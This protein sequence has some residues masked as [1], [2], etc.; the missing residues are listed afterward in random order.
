MIT[1]YHTKELPQCPS[2]KKRLGL[3]SISSYEL[4]GKLSPSGKLSVGRVPIKK[5][6]RSD[7]EYERTR[8]KYHFYQRRH[9]H[10]QQGLVVEN[11]IRTIEPPGLGL[12][13]VSNCHK[14]NRVSRHGLKGISGN[15]RKIVRESCYV[16]EQKYRK[17]LGFYTLTCPYTD[18]ESIYSYNKNIAYIQRSFFQELKRAYERKGCTWSYVS[19][20]EI[21]AKRYA[22]TGVPVLHIH[23]ISPCY[24]PGTYSWILKADEIRNIWG[25]VLSNIIFPVSSTQASID[26]VVIAK[27][28]TGYISKYMSKGSSEVAFLAEICPGQLPSQWWSTSRNVRACVRAN[29]CVLPLAVCQSFIGGRYGDCVHPDDVLY[30]RNIYVQWNAEMICVGLTA[31]IADRSAVSLRPFLEWQ[32]MYGYL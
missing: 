29:T 5:I 2:T 12:S 30:L 13:S 17:R 20:L 28:A 26:A 7:E 10:Y 6:L 8:G 1:R 16:L 15:G 27:S 22:R 23:Y 24:V 9:W 32:K 3:G 21:Q 14:D 19:V 11:A 4:V 25:N 31:D 18:L